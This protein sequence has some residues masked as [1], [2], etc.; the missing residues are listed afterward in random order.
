MKK[1]FNLFLIFLLFAGTI[2]F[3]QTNDYAQEVKSLMKVGEFA[4]A[5]NLLNEYLLKN[6]EDADAWVMNANLI[7]NKYRSASSQ[8]SIQSNPNESVY[9]SSIGFIAS[10]PVTLPKVVADSAIN[11]LKS[12]LIFAAKR[13][14][15][16]QGLCYLY[17][18][19]NRPLEL[20]K[21]LHALQAI[22]PGSEDDAFMMADY[23]RNLIDRNQ[24]N[25]GMQVYAAIYSMYMNN[26]GI[27]SDMAGEYYKHGDMDIALTYAKMAAEKKEIDEMTY[28]NIFFLASLNEEY[29]LASDMIQKQCAISK[30]KEYLVYD[31]LLRMIKGENAKGMFEEFLKSPSKDEVLTKAAR[32]MASPK[33]K[34]ALSDFDTLIQFNLND[35]YKVLVC[36]YFHKKYPNNFDPSFQL[37]EVYTYHKVYVKAAIEFKKTVLDDADSIDRRLYNMYAGWTYYNLKDYS[38]AKSHFEALSNSKDFYQ[39]SMACYFLGVIHEFNKDKTTALSYYQKA[40]NRASESKYALYCDWK[41]KTLGEQ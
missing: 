17:S 16:Q 33:F 12:A 9:E 18:I 3:A 29:V 32:Y 14:D 20:M 28:G 30:S 34:S 15:V 31:G 21:Q 13:I 10:P 39:F 4:K 37:A 6:P 36:N 25:D 27:L 23:A 8:I 22:L 41:L 26:G 38:E 2:S 35:P 24:F 19:S 5:E 1:Y 11:C 7:L 40:A